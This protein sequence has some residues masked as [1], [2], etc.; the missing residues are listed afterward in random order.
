MTLDTDWPP[1]VTDGR[2]T[3]EPISAARVAEDW[4]DEAARAVAG[5]AEPIHLQQRLDAGDI[6]WW[7]VGD[8]NVVGALSARI[9]ASS[10][11]WTW[12]AIDARWRAFGYGGAAVP[13]FED[14][15]SQ[16]GANE[17]LVP[18]PADNGV[19]LYFWLR[20][21][22]VPLRSGDVSDR[23]WM[24]RSLSDVDTAESAT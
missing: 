20:L 5:R 21:G 23:V 18:L 6:G 4:L 7:I 12:L 22:Y 8:G 19:A 13:L 10:A 2:T 9:E 24:R 3:I 15:A 17:A 1:S 16:R 11:I 14:A